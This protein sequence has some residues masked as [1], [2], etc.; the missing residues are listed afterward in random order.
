MRNVR[1]RAWS[2]VNDK[3]GGDTIG[4]SA[5]SRAVPRRVTV[6]PRTAEGA[7]AYGLRAPADPAEF[8]AANRR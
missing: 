3:R 5:E 7:T 4:K 6:G 1:V 2:T 8:T